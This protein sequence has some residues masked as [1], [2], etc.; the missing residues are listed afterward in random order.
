MEIQIKVTSSKKRKRV[1]DSFVEHDTDTKTEYYAIGG[2]CC[3]SLAYNLR[4][5]D[6]GLQPAP[7][8]KNGSNGLFITHY[9]SQDLVQY[10]PFCGERIVYKKKEITLVEIDKEI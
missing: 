2:F 7:I 4:N 1:W 6:K 10:C 8:M 9:G 3:H 5:M